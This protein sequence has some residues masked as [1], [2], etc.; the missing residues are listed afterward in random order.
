MSVRRR[1]LDE[2]RQLGFEI[3]AR[4][5]GPAD[6][7]RFLQ[8]F[9]TGQGD[10]TEERHLWL[11]QLDGDTIVEMI[12]QRRQQVTDSGEEATGKEKSQSQSG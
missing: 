7:I 4:E 6:F 2:I 8:Q 12:E 1:T 9:E 11:D 3:L 10:Y 5:L